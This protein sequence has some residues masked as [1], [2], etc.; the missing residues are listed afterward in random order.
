M[1]CGKSILYLQKQVNKK[2]YFAFVPSRCKSWHCPKCKPIKANQ[3]HEYVKA[4]FSEPNIFML[5]LTFY[6]SGPVSECWEN[7]G[8]YWNRL[9]TYVAKK[10]GKFSY[11]RIVEP[12]KEGGWPHL[13]VVMKGS[14]FHP[15]VVQKVTDWGFGWNMHIKRMHFKA[16]AH[17]IAKYLTKAW[18]D[19]GAEILRQSTKTR[20]C[21]VSRDLPSLFTKASDWEAVRYA[22]P[23]EG[24]L[25]VCNALIQYLQSLKADIIVS[26]RYSE[27][28]VIESSIAIDID[29]VQAL[30]EKYVWKYSDDFNYDYFP[31]GYQMEACF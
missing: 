21:S 1:E 3:V 7:I 25:F 29:K 24:S 19:N 5:T 26:T 20:I 16:A 18:P 22:Q 28:F 8:K 12:H 17:Y 15:D 23:T 4:N 2:H 13:H 27:G 30:N 9:R 11:L 6:H 14:N 10:Y 31:N